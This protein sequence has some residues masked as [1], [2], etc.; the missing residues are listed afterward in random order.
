MAKRTFYG[1]KSAKEMNRVIINMI[2]DAGTKLGDDTINGILLPSDSNLRNWDGWNTVEIVDDKL[3]LFNDDKSESEV[4][5]DEIEDWMSG[6]L[7]IYE[8]M[9]QILEGK[10]RTITHP[11]KEIAFIKAY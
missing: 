4:V 1:I 8:T 6:T 7:E 5:S 2:K 9:F 10:K 11:I 3:V